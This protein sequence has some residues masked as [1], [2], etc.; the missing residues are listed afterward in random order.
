MEWAIC[1]SRD[2]VMY[3]VL[4]FFFGLWN[5]ASNC[6]TV[7]DL[8][9]Q[10]NISAAFGEVFEWCFKLYYC[11]GTIP[12]YVIQQIHWCD[13]MAMTWKPKKCLTEMQQLL[14]VIG[15]G[16]FFILSSTS[17]RFMLNVV[18]VEI[19]KKFCILTTI[20]HS[21]V[22]CFYFVYNRWY[23]LFCFASSLLLFLFL[24]YNSISQ[25]HL[26]DR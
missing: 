18:F 17:S 6:L 23:F 16:V 24:K 13:T 14:K 2:D 5:D 11:Y 12:L 7:K 10:R 1:R 19:I 15:C 9:F 8:S 22:S 25:V 3:Q 4:L 21:V 20:L 26:D